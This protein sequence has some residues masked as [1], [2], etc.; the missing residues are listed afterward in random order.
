MESIPWNLDW[1][2]PDHGIQTMKESRP[3]NPDHG[4][5]TMESR[6]WNPD[7]GIQTM[8][9][10]PWNPDRGIQT[11]ESRPWNPDHGIQTMESRPWNPNRFLVLF[12]FFSHVR[13]L[14]VHHMSI[15]PFVFWTLRT[16]TLPICRHYR[17]RRV[18]SRIPELPPDAISRSLYISTNHRAANWTLRDRNSDYE[19]L[20]KIMKKL[21]KII[22]KNNCSL[23]SEWL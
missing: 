12:S 2:N 18:R 6:P 8:E 19:K 13:L 17:S 3:W 15:S 5:Q 16:W 1:W 4:I 21:W 23:F 9:S 7:H 22:M 14:L 20:W 10:R 11:M